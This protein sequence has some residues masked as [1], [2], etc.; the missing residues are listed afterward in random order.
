MRW[1]WV[2]GYHFNTSH[3]AYST[4]VRDSSLIEDGAHVLLDAGDSSTGSYHNLS[5]I[6]NFLDFERPD[7]VVDGIV[8]SSAIYVD[9]KGTY[10]T[11]SAA[12]NVFH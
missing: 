11:N 12:W 9:N 7:L 8:D 10:Y 6:K 4:L 5:D 2:L 1:P 3:L